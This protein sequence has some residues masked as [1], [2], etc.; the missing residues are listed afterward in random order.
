VNLFKPNNQTHFY[1]ILLIAIHYLI[2][3][4]FVGQVI[5]EPHD[6]LDIAVV[7]DHVIS[8]IYKGDIEKISYFLSGEIKW[9]YLEKL[10][11]PINILHY[12]LNDK[13]FYFVN[14]ILKKLFP[15]FSFFILAR[16]LGV[17][18]F[19][20]AL[21]GILY[22]SLVY[23]KMPVGLGMA[24]LPYILYL[25]LE[26]DK[27]NKKH[28]FFLF[29]IGLN[30]SLIQDIFAF[31]FLIPLAILLKNRIEN[32]TIYLKVFSLI[33]FSSILSNIHLVI[34]SI[35]SST[36]HRESWNMGNV[37][38]SP[39]LEVIKEFFL[40]TNFEDP[41]F[42]FY[43]PLAFLSALILILPSFSKQKK[44]II[45]IFF[46][47]FIL[48]LKSILH[49]NFIDHILVGAFDVFKGFNF[50]RVDRIIPLA[51]TLLL[52]LYIGILK[53]KVFKNFLYFISFLAII[54][55]Q[56]KVPLPE[57]G[58]Y[59]LNKN[60]HAEKFVKVKKD[61]SEKKYAQVFK[62][63]IDKKNY[64]K[65][66]RNFDDSIIKT[67]NNYY[68]FKDYAFIRNI[69]K[70][71]R[72]MSV[73]LDPMIAVMNDIKVV[74]GYHNIYPLSYKIK[75]RK[76][77]EAELEKNIMLKDYYDDWGSRVYA[78]YTDKNNIMLNFQAAKKLKADFVISKFPIE[79]KELKVICYKCNNS[80]YIFLYKIL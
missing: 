5:I 50:Q 70:N 75:F 49:H 18:R 7:Y 11:F 62:I 54:C 28:Y 4:I 36:I 72:V 14:D 52:I 15:Y 58:K 78:F 79:N 24:F 38:T 19:N 37:A 10:F 35:V 53:K 46:I 13:L 59:F 30:S 8:Y 6:N 43:L 63:I 2:P 45:L 69:V 61:F 32:L 12:V 64:T 26:K 66:E 57:L 41:L 73:G 23:I 21:G 40:K 34:G 25:L 67:F 33:L 65:N 51:Y 29:L 1:F 3:L 31:I 22:S 39:F 47:I 77:I 76:V 42:I 48:I 56:L 9:Y 55:I 80:D 27:L 71:S 17:A 68:K 20:S 60:M 74:D 44:I 16:S